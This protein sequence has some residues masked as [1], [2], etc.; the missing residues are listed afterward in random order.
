MD[1]PLNASASTAGGLIS[2]STFEVPPYQREYSWREDEVREFFEDIQRSLDSDSYF[3]GL[4]I[5]TDE[6]GRKK[7]VDGQQRVVTLTLLASALYH[8]AKR[9]GR[10]ALAERLN[11]DFLT[12]INYE[13]D[14]SDPRVIL[15]DSADNETLQHIVRT[16]EVP[17]QSPGNS[18]SVSVEICKSYN[19]LVKELREDLKPDP[20]KRLGKWTEFITNKLY[21]AVFV[22][23]SPSSAY[24]VFEVIN[25]RGKDLTTADLLKN[26]VISQVPQ[27]QRG[28]VYDRWKRIA[29]SFQNDGTNSFVQYIRH[30]V[31]VQSGHILPKDLFSFLASRS[32]HSA[33]I[34]PAPLA[35]IEMLEARLPLYL[36]MVDPSLPG[37][38][39]E[40]ALAVFRALNRLNVITMRPLM[41][42]IT[43]AADTDEGL[44][45]LLRLVVRRIVVGNLGTGNIERRF[46]EAARKVAES[47]QWVDALAELNDLS[48]EKDFFTERL[49]KRSLN[50][51]VLGYLRNTILAEN[52]APD[53][54]YFTH[55]I[56]PKSLKNHPDFEEGELAFWGN[57][58]GNTFLSTEEARADGGDDWETFQEKMFPLAAPNELTVDLSAFDKWNADSIREMGVMLA[59]KAAE[60][61]YG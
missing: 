46:A 6:D 42:A 56:I 22:H 30:V 37:P 44:N 57:T 60:V 14:G 52:I 21:F 61:W 28:Q 53:N 18:D 13:T 55:F 50:K 25:T 5:L 36:Q 32:E 35:L 23:P 47:S 17:D 59:D 3:L 11:A 58:I 4:I 16:G 19:F 9:R 8:E 34:A 27:N 29:D 39:D 51:A 24:Q 20:F 48:P 54:Y 10:S 38:A 2:G 12:S 26:F 43:D 31:T 1:T 45:Q 33:R 40:H 7:I 49:S 15:T 41:M